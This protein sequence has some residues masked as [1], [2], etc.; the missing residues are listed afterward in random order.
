MM[1]QNS[2]I[3]VASMSVAF[4]SA[5]FMLSDAASATRVS[6]GIGTVTSA[7]CSIEPNAARAACVRSSPSNENGSVVNT[8]AT[9]PR[10]DRCLTISAVAPPPV[11]PPRAV[12]MMAVRTPSRCGVRTSGLSRNAARA[13]AECPPAP[14][15]ARRSPPSS[16]KGS[17]DELS[18]TASESTMSARRDA[19]YARRTPRTVAAPVP[20]TPSSRSDDVSGFIW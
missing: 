16:T 14:R 6:R 9:I 1:R 3:A 20:P 7:T 11:P 5:S 19:P 12:M 13:S 4:A 8:T 10:A 2:V 18:V 15:P 17:S